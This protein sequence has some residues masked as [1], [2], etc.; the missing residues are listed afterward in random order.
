MK[1]RKELVDGEK[2]IEDYLTH[3]SVQ[4]NVALSTQNQEMNALVFLY[5]KILKM[6]LNDEINAIRAH[7]KENLPV[8]MTRAPNA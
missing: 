3:L 2:K 8:V 5:K 4:E 7:K 6:P 1:S